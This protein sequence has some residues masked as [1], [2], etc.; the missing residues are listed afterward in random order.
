MVYRDGREAGKLKEERRDRY[1]FSYETEY[2]E[3]A[4]A[5]AISLTL[6]KRK[7]EYVEK[8]LFPF[9]FNMLSEGANKAL[10]CRHLGIEENDSFGLLLATAQYD[11]AGAVT[12]KPVKE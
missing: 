1:V 4:E 8:Y 9:F 10:Q 12:L 6:P 2:L 7:E 3:D 11:T 5:P